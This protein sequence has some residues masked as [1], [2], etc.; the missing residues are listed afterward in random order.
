[1]P[2]QNNPMTPLK[3]KR[4]IDTPLAPRKK[5]RPETVEQ[6]SM[7]TVGQPSMAPTEESNE[8]SHEESHVSQAEHPC[9]PPDQMI[10]PRTDPPPLRI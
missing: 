9:T 7:E 10:Q 3:N 2:P 8:E 1:M 4:I 5:P 6:P